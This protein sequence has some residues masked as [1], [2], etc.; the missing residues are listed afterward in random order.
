MAVAMLSKSVRRDPVLAAALNPLVVRSM[1]FMLAAAGLRSAGT[2]GQLRA[3]GLAVAW[4]RILP[5]WAEDE[6]P[7][8]ARTMVVVDREISRGER[9]EA[10][11]CRVRNAFG[12]FDERMRSRRE[13]PRAAA[14]EMSAGE[15]I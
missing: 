11:A 4:A 9:A 6:D 3:Q 10:F 14:E 1:S 13:P 12:R 2:A 7:G 15:G 8:L 5:V